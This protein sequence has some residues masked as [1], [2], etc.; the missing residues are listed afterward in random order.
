[1]LRMLFVT[2][3][4]LLVTPAFAGTAQCDRCEAMQNATHTKPKP[5]NTQLVCVRFTQ[6]HAGPVVL[7]EYEGLKVIRRYEKQAG[8][9]G[10]FCIGRHW[11]ERSS[12]IVICNEYDTRGTEPRHTAILLREG[13]GYV[14]LLR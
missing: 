13:Y 5:T 2:L 11:V 7:E 9:K 8:T 14:H 6:D 1:M 3:A 10:Q 12:K 4:F